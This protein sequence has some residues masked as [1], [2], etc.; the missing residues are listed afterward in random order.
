MPTDTKPAADF[1]V[2]DAPTAQPTPAAQWD[3]A[4]KLYRLPSGNIARLARPA[5]MVLAARGLIPN[6]YLAAIRKLLAGRDLTKTDAERWDARRSA[7][8]ARAA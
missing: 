3:Q 4:P 6:P 8:P 7:S 5:L 2:A 1:I